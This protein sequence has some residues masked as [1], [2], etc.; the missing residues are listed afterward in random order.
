MNLVDRILS[1]PGRWRFDNATRDEISGL[2]ALA[3]QGDEEAS[4]ALLSR[5]T[6]YIAQQVKRCLH[7]FRG[8]ATVEDVFS[9]AKVAVFEAVA[10][11]DETRGNFT[12]L[13]QLLV[14]RHIVNAIRE[15]SKHSGDDHQLLLDE[16]N[17]VQELERDEKDPSEVLARSELYDDLFDALDT[18]TFEESS[19]VQAVHV[20]C[21]NRHQA[22][23]ALG[24]HPT[25]FAVVLATAEHKIRKYIE[26]R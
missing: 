14:R 4:H 10:K 20:D 3:K 18:L 8:D 26:A 15:S 5:Y 25:N 9:A 23:K 24:I 19:V 21:L 22:A 13:L 12:P 7:G 2:V 1:E 17:Q 11:F 16:L 6:Y